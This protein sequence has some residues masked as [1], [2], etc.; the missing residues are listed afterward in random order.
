MRIRTAMTCLLLLPAGTVWG[1]DVT[2]LC[3]DFSVQYNIGIAPIVVNSANWITGLDVPGEYIQTNFTVQ[4]FGTDRCE[5]V[6]M[7]TD[8]VPF[9]VVMT[10]TGA[11]SGGTQEI[12]FDFIGSGFDG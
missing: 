1:E 10:L 9:R 2:L 5:L 11:W 6:A 12:A 3:R 4:G 8:G 7:G